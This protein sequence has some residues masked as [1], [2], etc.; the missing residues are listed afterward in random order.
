MSKISIITIVKN[1]PAGVLKTIESVKFQTIKPFQFILIDGGSSDQ[2]MEV[3]NQHKDTFDLIISEDDKGIYDAMN[4]GIKNADGDWLIFMNAGDIF[5]NRD[6]IENLRYEMNAYEEVDIF[7]SD[8]IVAWKDKKR[9][10]HASQLKRKFI[11]QSICYK[12]KLHNEFGNY[13]TIK[14][15]NVADYLF[16]IGLPVSVSW[17]KLKIIISEIDPYGLSSNS[18]N[19]KQKILVDILL[20]FIS[21]NSGGMKI[22]IHPLYYGIKRKIKRRYK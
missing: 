2:T 7:Y 11:H 20:G 14:G 21:F 1:D 4:K 10:A 3:V 6:A 19:F 15:F 12:K 22:L 5:S 8:T 18:I 9:V 13:I 17:K 16:F